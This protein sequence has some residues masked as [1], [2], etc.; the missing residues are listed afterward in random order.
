V[1]RVL[2]LTASYVPHK[3]ISWERAV[4]MYFS[5]KVEIVDSWDEELRAPSLTMLIPSVVRLKR[6][7]HRMKRSVKFSRMNVFTRDGF[8]CQYCG[9]PKRMNDLNYDHVVPRHLGGRTTWDNIVASCYPCNSRKAN[10][11]PEQAGMKLLRKPYA[12]H[13][14][15]VAPPRFDAKE[16]PPS[17]ADYVRSFFKDEAAA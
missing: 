12:P 8:R 10:R 15:P 6:E 7:P 13:S 5:G 3:V 2:V 16:V 1:K 17:W 9:S 4:I 11:T 14:L